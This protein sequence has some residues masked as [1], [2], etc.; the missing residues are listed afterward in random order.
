MRLML[1]NL[2]YTEQGRGEGPPVTAE[3]FLNTNQCHFNLCA[4]NSLYSAATTAT[5]PREYILTIPETQMIQTSQAS[6][7]LQP[8]TVQS[9]RDIK[10]VAFHDEPKK[11]FQ[12]TVLLGCHG[13]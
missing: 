7:F 10:T 6:Q 13:K 5:S 12:P 9:V 11:D 8:V 1:K 2:W 4:T 3:Y